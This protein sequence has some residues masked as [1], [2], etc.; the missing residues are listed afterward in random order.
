[1]NNFPIFIL[2][3]LLL[4]VVVVVTVGVVVVSQSVCAA[5]LA[6][7]VVDA[8]GWVTIVVQLEP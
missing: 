7:V 2:V 4:L 6:E 1:M 8:V 3:P 5:V